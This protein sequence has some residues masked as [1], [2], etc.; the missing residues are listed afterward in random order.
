VKFVSDPQEGRELRLSSGDFEC[1]R[2][3]AVEALNRHDL[4]TARRA[5]DEIITRIPL[6]ARDSDIVKSLDHRIGRPKS[7]KRRSSP[8]MAEAQRNIR[9]AWEENPN[10]THKEILETLD[11][12]GN[13]NPYGDPTWVDAFAK[14]SNKVKTLISKN[15]PPTR[16]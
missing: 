1:L 7:R 14:N 5:Y 13:P 6:E 2:R 10:A 3:E 11:A 16:S 8:Q 12:R 4:I 15:R 9:S